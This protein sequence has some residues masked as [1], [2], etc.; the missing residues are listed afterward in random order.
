Y[1]LLKET[2]SFIFILGQS[3][4]GTLALWLANKY[5]EINGLVLINAALRV[6][7]Y[8]QFIG[9]FFPRYLSETTPDIKLEDVQEITYN[10]VPLHSIFE[11]QTV[12]K[13]TPGILKNISNPILCFKSLEDHVVPPE[14]TDYILKHV[15]SHQKQA[16]TL[17]NSYHVASMDYDKDMI[18]VETHEYIKKLI[19]KNTLL[20]TK[21]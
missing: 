15:E 2:C 10:K 11:L 9:K 16:I 5:K 3:M 18:V 21:S 8:D 20:N 13:K 14:D 4:G 1:T 7:E 19:E 17:Y 12:M 6:P